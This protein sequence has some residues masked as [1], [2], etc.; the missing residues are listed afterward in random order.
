[1]SIEQISIII[2]FLKILYRAV[3]QATY[4]VRRLALD[5]V[6]ASRS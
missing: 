3:F 5:T 4:R 1:L 6:T 2:Q